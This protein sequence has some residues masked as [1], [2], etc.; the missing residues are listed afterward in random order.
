[1]DERIR[2]RP[3]GVVRRCCHGFLG[4]EFGAEDE[5]NEGMVSSTCFKEWSE[6]ER[7][8]KVGTNMADAAW[9]RRRRGRRVRFKIA[10]SSGRAG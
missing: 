8:R 4:R 5:R 7:E 1:M 9:V 10:V 6:G 3:N 2:S